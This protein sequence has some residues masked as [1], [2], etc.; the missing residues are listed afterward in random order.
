MQP[1]DEVVA[2]SQVRNHGSR[3]LAQ[4]FRQQ[5]GLHQPAQALAAA[6]SGHRL[7]PQFGK[8]REQ[9]GHR[10]G[11]ELLGQHRMTVYQYAR[12]ELGDEPERVEQSFG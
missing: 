3:V 5:A 8:R 2:D 7:V 6:D 12:A 11:G 10:G 4:H 9:A 1:L